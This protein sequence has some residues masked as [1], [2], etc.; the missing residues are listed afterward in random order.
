MS[1]RVGVNGVSHRD[2]IGYN[3]K[4]QVAGM[5]PPSCR[6]RG[7]EIAAEGVHVSNKFSMNVGSK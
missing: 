1:M 5:I 6:V 3:N 4:E 7:G 2:T